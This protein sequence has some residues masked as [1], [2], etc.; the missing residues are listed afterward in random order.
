MAGTPSVVCDPSAWPALVAEL[1]GYNPTLGAV[2]GVQ[3]V[4][5]AELSVTGDGPMAAEWASAAHESTAK[6]PMP[7]MPP[8]ATVSS[9]SGAAASG[10]IGGGRGG[11]NGTVSSEAGGA[12]SGE[13]GSGRAAPG[14]TEPPVPLLP[15]G[16]RVLVALADGLMHSALIRQAMQ[17]Y[18]ELEI[19]ASGDTVWVPVNM[20]SPQL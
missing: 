12:V 4:Q 9:A 11:G 17:G 14:P 18:Y 2:Y 6:G 10:E 16:S 5:F 19:E 20:V 13:I 15:N 7:Q 8:V 1:S 3:F